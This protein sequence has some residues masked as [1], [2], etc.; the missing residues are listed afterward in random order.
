MQKNKYCSILIACLSIFYACKK[1]NI[2]HA[3][4]SEQTGAI[5]LKFDNRVGTEELILNSLFYKNSLDESYTV[6]TLSYQIADIELLKEDG[7]YLKITADTTLLSID[8]NDVLNTW[9][10]IQ[11]VPLGTYKGLRFNLKQNKNKILFEQSGSLGIEKIPYNIVS[12]EAN[13][14]IVLAFADNGLSVKQGQTRPSSAHIF[15]DIKPFAK[16]NTSN[17]SPDLLKKMFEVNH[18]E[19]Y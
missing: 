2:A 1:D 18:V 3:L 6:Q 4:N 7:N 12:T 11:N 10:K 8:E 17:I 5:L 13:I 16:S 9:R 15:A 14:P 19:N